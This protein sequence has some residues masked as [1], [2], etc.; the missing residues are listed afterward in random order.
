MILSKRYVVT[1]SDNFTFGKF[2]EVTG[3]IHAIKKRLTHKPPYH[4]CEMVIGY[5][6]DHSLKMRWI[7][8]NP[9]IAAVLTAG[10]LHS[11]NIEALFEACKTNRPFR[12]AYEGYIKQI[13]LDI[14]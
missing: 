1:D 6:K 3:E 2:P 13:L 11:G 10:E 8:L 14:N 12:A 4:K 5:L 9:D 7:E